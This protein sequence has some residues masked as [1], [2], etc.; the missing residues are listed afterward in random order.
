ME[1]Y[2]LEVVEIPTNLPGRPRRRGRRGLPDRRRE[3]QGH[4]PRDRGGLRARPADPRRHDLDREVRAPRR[5]AASKD[6]F[7]QIDFEDPKALEPLYDAARE[8]RGREALRRA[9]RPLPRAGG[10]HRRPGRRAG[11][12]HHR[13]QHGRPRHRHPARRQRQDARRAGDSAASKGEERARAR[14]GDPRR[15]RPR[16]RSGRSRPAASTC[17]APSGTNPAAS[18]TSCAAAP[19]ARAIPAARSSTCR[20]RTT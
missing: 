20:S 13:D 8:G 4:H 1:I 18:T 3:V 16:S 14:D 6:G 11:R 2:N 15:D 12:D 7:T 5:A 17:S 19:A 9:Q 10:L